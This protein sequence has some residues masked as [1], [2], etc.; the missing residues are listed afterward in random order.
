[1]SHPITPVLLARAEAIG[2][3][4]LFRKLALMAVEVMTSS[5]HQALPV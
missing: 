4:A 5:W 3:M 2:V 1:M